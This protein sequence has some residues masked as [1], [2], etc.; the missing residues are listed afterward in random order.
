M[1]FQPKLQQRKYG[2]Q[3]HRGKT[4]SDS[5]SVTNFFRG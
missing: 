3:F 2:G 1:N 5:L 4:L